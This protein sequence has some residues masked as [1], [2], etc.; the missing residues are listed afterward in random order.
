MYWFLNFTIVNL[1]NFWTENLAVYFLLAKEKKK[2][3]SGNNSNKK[4]KLASGIPLLGTS[5]AVIR[6]ITL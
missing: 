6:I 3:W 4:A 2:T 5:A 1:S